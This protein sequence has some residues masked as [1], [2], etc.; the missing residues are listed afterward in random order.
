MDGQVQQILG[1]EVAVRHHGD[2]VGRQF[3]QTGARVGFGERSRFD[4]LDAVLD[5]HL[6]DRRGFERAAA[7]HAGVRAGEHRDDLVAGVL[8]QRAQRGDGGL[9]GAGEN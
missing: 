5:R 7:A 9:G 2:A 6:L 4:D 8:D 3:G 1:H